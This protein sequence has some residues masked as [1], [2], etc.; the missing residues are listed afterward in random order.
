M[1]FRQK[2]RHVN[3]TGMHRSMVEGISPKMVRWSRRSDDSRVGGKPG[4]Q[5]TA[6]T[7]SANSRAHCS[8]EVFKQR[9]GALDIGHFEPFGEPVINW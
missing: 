8:I 9:F 4:Q 2:C 1:R 3:S 5:A 7:K 6:A